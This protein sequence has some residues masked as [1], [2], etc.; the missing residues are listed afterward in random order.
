MHLPSLKIQVNII[1]QGL[2]ESPGIVDMVPT[3]GKRK[4]APTEALTSLIGIVKPVGA[5]LL[6]GS[7]ERDRCVLAMQM[8]RSPKPCFLYLSILTTASGSSSMSSAP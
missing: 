1:K 5:P 6:D 2:V 4:P 7:A 8:G 3:K